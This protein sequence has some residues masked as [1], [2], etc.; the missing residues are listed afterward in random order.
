MAKKPTYEE[1]E[2][3]I[4]ELEQA[5]S[6]LDHISDIAY[7]ADTE[8]NVTYVNPAAEQIIGIP[9]D[10]IIGKPFLPFFIEEDHQSLIDVY[11]R[12]LAGESLEN[13]LTFNNGVICHFTSIPLR[14]KQG[15]IIGT[16]GIARD[17]SQRLETEKALAESEAR[18]KKAQS[19][20]KI[21]N[22]EYDLSTG[23]I[24][25]SEQAFQ[26][27]GIERT[28]PYLP[29]D[30]VEACIPD[31]ARVNQALVDLIQKN[32]KYDIE[33]E[34]R[35]ETTGR[36]ILIHSIAELVYENNVPTKVLG[37]IQDFT[38]R[39]RAEEALRESEEKY[40]ILV[41][42]ANDA[43]FITQGEAIKFPNPKT[44]DISGYS[45]EEL[46]RKPFIELI[47]PEDRDLILETQKKRL[48]GEEL[49]STYP[50]RIINKA[51]VPVW[52]QLNTVLINWEGHPANLNL[53]RDITQ[54]RKLESQLQ[55]AQKMEAIGTLAGGIAHDFNNIL[56][57]IIGF[58]EILKYSKIPRDSDLQND[59]DQ[60]LKAGNRAKDLVKQILAF[61]RQVEQEE[62]PLL[63][64]PIVAET[65]KLLR[66]TLPTTIEI[67]EG[68]EKTNATIIGDPSQINQIIMNLCTNAAHAM[69]A[70]GGV[71]EVNLEE[72]EIDSRRSKIRLNLSP[73][74][75]VRL[76]VS[77]TGHG[78]SP[79]IIERV[80][81]PYF[82]TKQKGEG[83]GLGLAVVHGIVKS[84]GG[85][86]TVESQVGKGTIFNIYMPMVEKVVS[87]EIDR[88][89]PLPTGNG[90]IL[91]VD[92]ENALVQIGKQMLAGLGYEVETRTSSLEALELF[93]MNPSRFD[94]VMTDMTMPNMT[95]AQ[96]A[97]ELIQIR[98]DIQI[99]LCTG[100][101]ERMNRETIVKAGIKDLL[102]KPL[103]T[104]EMALSVKNALRHKYGI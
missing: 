75:Y 17:I 67:I 88:E 92:D 98:P 80:F 19:V 103:S 89:E 12:T 96:L 57:A 45:K 47:H 38:E 77:D 30:R 62:K 50:F 104:R 53:I 1:L 6:I 39:K 32:K 15:N 70:S 4:Q 55:Q 78:I 93:R 7:I 81:D 44:E 74:P 94:L 22:W 54:Q 2:L 58:G 40:R 86:I 36:T 34:V 66:A 52:V 10:E 56:G 20:A 24:W 18:L 83:T 69:Q 101:S 60:I 48:G 65:L 91:F 33:F 59:L 82:T 3:R 41:E 26:I 95:G 16:S 42:N 21:G 99:I 64:V 79:E 37:V 97:Q 9:L 27:Y 5:K 43:I 25:G 61:S 46:I 71:L 72:V 29:L 28:S 11:I 31:A 68:I 13:T 73:G 85:E 8:G 84:H 35:Q 76:T 23:K 100:F 87:A 102:L 49:P 90:R 63:I 51:G 14:D